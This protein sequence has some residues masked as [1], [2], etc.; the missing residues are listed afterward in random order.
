MDKENVFNLATKFG[1]IRYKDG[2][3][4]SSNYDKELV[5]LVEALQHQDEYVFIC[6]RCGDD[7]GIK[8]VEQPAQEPAYQVGEIVNPYGS[9]I[10]I[11]QPAQE[12]FEKGKRNE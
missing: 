10:K 6:K 3:D 8:Y 4:W 1:F 7:L 2:I 11:K 9:N 12:F 5:A